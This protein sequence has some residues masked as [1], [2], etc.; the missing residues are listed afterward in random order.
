[1]KG[2]D[3]Q[4]MLVYYTY[5]PLCLVQRV[6]FMDNKVLLSHSDKT[7]LASVF[8]QGCICHQLW[9]AARPPHF[10]NSFHEFHLVPIAKDIQA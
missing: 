1:M 2:P 3:K 9:F 7:G 5:K 6:L 8:L 4:C 10:W